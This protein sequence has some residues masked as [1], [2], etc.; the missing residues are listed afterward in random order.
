MTIFLHLETAGD[1]GPHHLLA[2]QLWQLTTLL[3][4]K[5]RIHFGEEK[6][7]VKHGW[8]SLWAV[9]I[10][11]SPESTSLIFIP[12]QGLE[13][14]KFA[15]SI[16]FSF[17]FTRNQSYCKL[18]AIFD[19]SFLSKFSCLSTQLCSITCYIFHLWLLSNTFGQPQIL[20]TL[21][22]AFSWNI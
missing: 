19:K 22:F 20:N 8:E 18:K 14:W 6:R 7:T 12:I 17:P 21:H 16:I 10:V 11:A 1:T 4:G 13:R 5:A 15:L 3:N 9:V 2:W